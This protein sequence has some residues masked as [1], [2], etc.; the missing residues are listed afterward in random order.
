MSPLY[1][2]SANTPSIVCIRTIA[3]NSAACPHPGTS[4]H[5]TR[6]SN[7]LLKFIEESKAAVALAVCQVV[8]ALQPGT[9]RRL[10]QDVVRRQHMVEEINHACPPGS[11]VLL[12]IGKN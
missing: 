10:E 2:S 11:A 1:L 6:P 12:I 9:V 4:P 3:K 7:V 8:E 5:S